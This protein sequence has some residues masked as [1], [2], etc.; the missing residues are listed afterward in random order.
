MPEKNVKKHILISVAGLTPQVITETLYHLTQLRT[1]P[2]TISEIFILTTSLGKEKIFSSLLA[3]RR[4]KYF[5]LLRDYNINPSSIQ[6][7][8]SHILILKDAQ[9]RELD[10]IRTHSDNEAV[11]DQILNFVREK[12]ADS[13]CRLHCSLAGGRKTMGL[14]LGLA[15]QLYGRPGDVLSHVLIY[16]PELEKDGDFFYPSPENRPFRLQDGGILKPDDIQVELAEIPIILLKGKIP[17]L[18][19][20]A[21]LGYSELVRLTQEEFEL[22]RSPMPLVI[23]STARSI[24]IGEISISL[25]P[26]WFALYLFLA[27]RRIESCCPPGCQ[28]CEVCFCRP[29]EFYEATTLAHLKSILQSMGFRNPRYKELSGWKST[30]GNEDAAVKRFR[31]VRSKINRRIKKSGIG[32]SWTEPYTIEPLSSSRWGEAHYGICLDKR[33]IKIN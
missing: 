24:H 18:Q 5:A 19:E 21:D 31:Q 10:D 6:F 25:P 22:L 29:D 14:Y 26:L 33:L 27:R 8:A 11:A 30:E 15:L 13:D 3:P 23:N 17:L 1:P 16:P 9:G 32:M 4:G 20:R 2:V 28:G 7:D 12:A